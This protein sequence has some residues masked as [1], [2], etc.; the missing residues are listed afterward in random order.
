MNIRL[1][2]YYENPTITVD[3][4]EINFV[5]ADTENH[6]NVFVSFQNSQLGFFFFDDSDELGPILEKA[7]EFFQSGLDKIEEEIQSLRENGILK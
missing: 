1:N 7:K 6:D 5:L 2:G 3:D 4:P